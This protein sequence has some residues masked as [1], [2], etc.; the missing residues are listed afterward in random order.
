MTPRN[1]NTEVVDVAPE[2]SVVQKY[3]TY[4]PD[5]V[6]PSYKRACTYAYVGGLGLHGISARQESIFVGDAQGDKASDFLFNYLLVAAGDKSSTFE[7]KQEHPGTV[8]YPDGEDESRIQ[9]EMSFFLFLPKKEKVSCHGRR[10]LRESFSLKDMGWG[11][12]AAV[13]PSLKYMPRCKRHL[14]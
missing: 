9:I 13:L 2:F 8:C 6:R 12:P 14:N 3:G 7:Y 11:P 1:I 4:T 10:L 5:Y